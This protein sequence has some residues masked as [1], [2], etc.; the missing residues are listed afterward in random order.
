M[1]EERRKRGDLIQL[2][3]IKSGLN[4]VNVEE[5]GCLEHGQSFDDDQH[6]LL[7][8]DSF[9]IFYLIILKNTFIVA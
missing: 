3:K 2:H 4:K 9:N 1:L 7:F 8:K 5:V 6:D